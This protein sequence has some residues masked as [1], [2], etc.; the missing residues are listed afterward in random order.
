[1]NQKKGE[2]DQEILTRLRKP[3]SEL[4]D[5]RCANKTEYERIRLKQLAWQ[6]VDVLIRTDNVA[7]LEEEKDVKRIIK[8]IKEIGASKRFIEDSLLLAI[9]IYRKMQLDYP[10]VLKRYRGKVTLLEWKHK[11]TGS[12]CRRFSITLRNKI[13]DELDF[14]HNDEVLAWIDEEGRI[15]IEKM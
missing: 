4:V 13:L 11:K 2:T 1:M 5:K 14:K 10:D 3:I 12:L 6:A 9:S 8:N 7:H 15:V